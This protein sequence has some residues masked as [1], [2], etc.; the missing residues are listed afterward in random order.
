MG[1]GKKK[2]LVVAVALEAC[3]L[4]HRHGMFKKANMGM[5]MGS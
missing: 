2:E 3:K 1:T 4:L 5:F